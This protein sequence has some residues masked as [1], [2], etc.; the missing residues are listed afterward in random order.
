MLVPRIVSITGN[1]AT[2]T[3]TLAR[4]LSKLMGWEP[5]YSDDYLNVNPYFGNFL[6]QPTRWA[7]HNQIFLIAE[8]IESYQYI[9]QSLNTTNRTSCLDYSIFEL[10][11]YTK[12]MHKMQYVDDAEYNTLVKLL[13]TYKL[14]VP[15][16]LIYLTAGIDVILE[17]VQQRGR[18]SES[19]I[20]REYI[21]KLQNDFDD[22]ASRWDSSPIIYIDSEKYNFLNTNVIEKVAKIIQRKL[23]RL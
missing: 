18:A 23:S 16:L 19:I 14:V 21:T 15:D 6:H 2:G 7:F 3:T 11:V 10:K 13:N 1:T 8:Y 22:Y 5:H 12:T 20:D 17:R 9:T 4:N